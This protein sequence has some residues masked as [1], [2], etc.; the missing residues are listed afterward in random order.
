MGP[1]VACVYGADKALP[2]HDTYIHSVAMPLRCGE[3]FKNNY[4][5]FTNASI[6]AQI[7]ENWLAFGKVTDKKSSVLGFF[8]SHSVK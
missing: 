1:L 7:F 4:C 3:I 8:D 2:L 5:K 6:S